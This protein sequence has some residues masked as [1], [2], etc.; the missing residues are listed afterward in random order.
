MWRYV[1]VCVYIHFYKVNCQQSHEKKT[2]TPMWVKKSGGKEKMSITTCIGRI[3]Y[4]VGG[5]AHKYRSSNMMHSITIANIIIILLWRH[6]F[7]YKIY[8]IPLVLLYIFLL[9]HFY[10]VFNW[11]FFFIAE[12]GIFTYFNFVHFII[13]LYLCNTCLWRVFTVGD[14]QM[15]SFLI[16]LVI[17]VSIYCKD[18]N[19]DSQQSS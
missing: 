16:S 2:Y 8:F 12:L 5:S 10:M 18:N 15:Q 17:K 6:F 4:A 13:H 1:Y 3:M 14:V 11:V 19:E 9:T 7:F